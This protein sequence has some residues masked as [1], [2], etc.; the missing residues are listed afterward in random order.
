MYASKPPV[1]TDSASPCPNE[2]P[3]DASLIT[4]QS[5]PKASRL[6]LPWRLISDLVHL[7]FPKACMACQEPIPLT[8]PHLDQPSLGQQPTDFDLGLCAACRN[9]L[10]AEVDRCCLQCGASL[11]DGF[12]E[13]GLQS[14]A[15]DPPPSSRVALCTDCAEASPTIHQCLSVWSY[16]PPLDAVMRGLKFQH[17]PYLARHLGHAIA[18]HLAAQL[19]DLEEVDAVVPVPLHWRRRLQ[20]GFDQTHLL[21]QSVATALDLPLKPVLRRRRATA[22]QSRLSRDARQHNLEQAF[23]L[24][25]GTPSEDIDAHLLLVDDVVTTGATLMAAARAL[26]TFQP[27]R[28]TAVTVARTPSP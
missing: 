23:T 2:S 12:Q 28:I 21:A 4:L 6:A 1:V 26:Q 7:V 16:Q 20:R 22:A 18:G 14:S 9:G 5:P 24:R 3:V 15:E 27:C 13:D 17:L 10:M 19:D 8:P 25:L 11:E